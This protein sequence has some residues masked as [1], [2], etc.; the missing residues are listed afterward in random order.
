MGQALFEGVVYDGQGQLL[1]GSLL[2]YAVP[3]ID[4]VPEFT[5]AFRTTPAAKNPL[6]VKGVGE[7]GCC[8]APPA[9]V[10]AVCDALRPFGITHIDMPLSAPKVWSAIQQAKSKHSQSPAQTKAA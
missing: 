7:A 1:T 5:I 6:G 10:A 8:A 4:Q 3:K 9:I 2:D